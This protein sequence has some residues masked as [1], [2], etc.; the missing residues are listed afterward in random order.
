MQEVAELIMESKSDINAD[1]V[2]LA[3]CAADVEMYCR[4]VPQGGGK[5]QLLDTN[6]DFYVC[7]F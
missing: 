6:L 7:Y 3:K 4:G 5:S 2:L 1:P